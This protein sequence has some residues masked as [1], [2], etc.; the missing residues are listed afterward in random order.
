MHP[1]P[2]NSPATT[3]ALLA[4]TLHRH[5]PDHSARL[6]EELF[7]TVAKLFAGK[8]PGYRACDMAYHDFNHT[9]DATVALGRLLDGHLNSRLAPLLN[10]RDYEVAVAAILWHDT[11]YLREFND[12]GGTGARYTRH[13]VER[14][15]SLAARFLPPLGFTA[16]EV[17]LVQNIIRWTEPSCEIDALAQ[18]APTEIFLGQAV[19]SADL[20]GQLAA[21]DYPHRLPDLF[22]EFAE[23]A[24][25]EAT[26]A[27]Y[28]PPC[29]LP[30]SLRAGSGAQSIRALPVGM[31]AK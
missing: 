12:D 1:I 18:R 19:G 4:D 6:I 17:I 13:H 29:V 7:D 21:P 28:S 26:T 15:A 10:A 22:Q 20:L 11:G 2:P 5:F 8:L 23:S 3:V 16:N 9:C 31:M 27:N 25:C 24:S 30:W 14:G